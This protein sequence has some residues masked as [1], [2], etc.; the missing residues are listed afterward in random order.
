MN[1]NLTYDS[2]RND[3]VHDRERGFVGRIVKNKKGEWFVAPYNV[4]KF[5]KMPDS[6]YAYYLNRIAQIVERERPELVGMDTP[7]AA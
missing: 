6:K 5:Q 7:V 2:Q 4:E 3:L 1:I